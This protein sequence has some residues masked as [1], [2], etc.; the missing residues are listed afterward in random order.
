MKFKVIGLAV[1]LG[2]SLGGCSNGTSDE[3][4]RACSDASDS[5]TT[6]VTD[7]MATAGIGSKSEREWQVFQ[8]QS[9][10]AKELRDISARNISSDLADRLIK[11]S[12]RISKSEKFLPIME[13]MN[14]FCI[15]NFNQDW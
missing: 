10:F 12:I 14:E 3:D 13:S 4:F 8:V 1:V 5:Q 7:Y 15:A 11:D 2:L 9:A 6:Y